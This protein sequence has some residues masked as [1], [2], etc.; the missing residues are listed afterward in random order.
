MERDLQDQLDALKT[1]LTNLRSDLKGAVT[2]IKDMGTRGVEVAKAALEGEAKQLREE[3]RDSVDQ[4]R[5]RGR[6]SLASLERQIEQNPY[7]S[8]ISAFGI[9]LL[10]GTLLDR[11]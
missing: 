7:M 8:L 5:E 6:D 9:G 10:L 4:A 2:M 1:D 3:F 11:R